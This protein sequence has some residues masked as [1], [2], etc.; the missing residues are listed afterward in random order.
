MLLGDRT[1]VIT[2]A[3]RGIGRACAV[4]AAE[5]G[6]DVVLLDIA[7]DLPEIPYRLG[8]AGQ[9]EHT[10]ELCRKNGASVLAAAADVRSQRA[11]AA[12]IAT[13][14]DRFGR[15][16]ALINNAG[17]GAPAGKA[18]HEFTEDE[19]RVV[20][21]VNLSG[22][23]RLTK[24]VAPVMVDQRGGSIVNVSSTAGLVGYRHFAGYV[25]SKHGLV[26]LTKAAALDYAPHNIRV[27]ALCPGP[28]RDDPTVDGQMTAVVADA[29][30]ISYE[31][32]E[33]VYLESVAMDSL[34]D[35]AD[36]AGAA[37]WLAGDDSRSV[38]GTVIT[39]DAGFSAR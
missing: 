38:T 30:G 1:V 11:V 25:A 19:W 16:D 29:L 12:V 22:P 37:V 35:P 20:L 9:L 32:Q 17:V 36:V 13:A 24:A 21:D 5:E 39:V 2:G 27:N 3:A 33:A 31:E 34:V 15:I 6:A 7:G 23:W 18:A 26:G 8:S 4:R 10:A 14:V 28:V